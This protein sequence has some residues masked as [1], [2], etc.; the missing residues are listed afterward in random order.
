M[1]AYT[2]PLARRLAGEL[3]G[4]VLLTAT[5]V[6]SGIMAQRLSGGSLALALLANTAATVAVLAALIALLL[7]AWELTAH[8]GLLFRDIVPSLFAIA[9]GIARVHGLVP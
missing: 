2:Q 5:V 3:L 6:G 8:S 1:S 4:S 7:C 9:D